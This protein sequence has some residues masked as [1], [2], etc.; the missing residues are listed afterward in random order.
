MTQ[1]EPG[2]VVQ[3]TDDPDPNPAVVVNRPP[4]TAAE[5]VAY[6]DTTVAEDNPEYP[7]D[8]PVVC[9]VYEAELPEQYAD[10]W[11]GRPIKIEHLNDE[12]CT[13]YTFPESRI[14][15]IGH[16]DRV[17]VPLESLSPYPL[18]QRTFDPEEDMTLVTEIRERGYPDPCP[19]VRPFGDGYQI[20]DGHKRVWASH[21]AEL[22]SI[23]VEV[24]HVD[25]QAAVEIYERNHPQ[26]NAE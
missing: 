4:V 26:D 9:V 8:D 2:A 24:Q 12:D 11:G 1:C 13:I 10:Y 22:E 17:T 23:P 25:D 14:E 18:Q 3:D 7:A 6:Y 21:V 16:R 19:L 15:V 20:L 5:W